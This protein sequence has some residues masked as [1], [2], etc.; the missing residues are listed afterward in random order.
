MKTSTAPTLRAR[1]IRQVVHA[2]VGRILNSRTPAAQRRAR[3]ETVGA[4]SRLPL[5]LGTR[6]E[7]T[8]LRG[9]PAEWLS[10]RCVE[11][12]RTVLY[13]HGG[14]YIVGSP[15]MYRD[16]SSRLVQH[17]QARVAVVDYRLAPEHPFPAAQEDALDA[18]RALLEQGI[19]PQDIVIAGDSAGGGLTL[20]TAIRARDAGLPQPAALILFSP[21]LDLTTDSESARRVGASG[22]DAMLTVDG[23]RRAARDYIGEKGNL[24]DPLASPLFADLRGLAPMLIQVTDREILFDDSRRLDTAVHQAGGASSLEI[25]PRLFHVWQL[26]AGKMPEAGRALTQAGEFL[27]RLP[28]A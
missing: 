28:Q 26:F 8:T 23:L 16:L 21:W 18:Y 3:L 14:G 2:T 11:A 24:N 4:M 25:W 6:V 19:A 27:D 13:L 1:L 12:K 7:P 10:N 22:E 20:A 15:R 5:P 9:V 17:W